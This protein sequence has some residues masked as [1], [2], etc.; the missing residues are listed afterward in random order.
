MAPDSPIVSVCIPTYN[1]AP[2][3]AQAIQ[4][5]L[6]QTLQDFELLISDNAST[7]DTEAVV[8]SFDDPRIRY[9][10]NEINLGGRANYDRCLQLASGS[11]VGR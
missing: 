6:G 9:V 4:S 1:R 3:L 10:R 7:D 5:V 11:R 8:R 2:L